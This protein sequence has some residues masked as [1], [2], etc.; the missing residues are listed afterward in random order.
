MAS[1][2]KVA[3]DKLLDSRD[4]WKDMAHTIFNLKE[5]IYIR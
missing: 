2:N 5:F 4:V 1:I 3:P